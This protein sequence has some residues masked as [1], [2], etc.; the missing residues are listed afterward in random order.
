MVLMVQMLSPC[1]YACIT[2]VP[3]VQKV[4]AHTVLYLVTVRTSSYCEDVLEANV[5]L[6]MP[7]ACPKFTP[8][9][10]YAQNEIILR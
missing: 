5:G 4:T 8:A 1:D 3:I 7:I 6:T 10:A 9:E 2:I